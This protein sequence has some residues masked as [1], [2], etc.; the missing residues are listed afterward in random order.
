M[1]GVDD[2]ISGCVWHCLL[3]LGV[4]I[5]NLSY[6]RRRLGE[7]FGFGSGIVSVFRGFYSMTRPV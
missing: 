5:F 3:I 2:Q 4:K 6:V 1:G 7:C